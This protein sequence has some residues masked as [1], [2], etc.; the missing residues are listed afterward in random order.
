MN[1]D[2]RIYGNNFNYDVVGD[3]NKINEKIEN[4]ESP[5][6]IIKLRLQRLYRGMELNLHS[7]KKGINGYYPY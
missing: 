4:E 7:F 2:L 5:E 3:I 1:K 6:E